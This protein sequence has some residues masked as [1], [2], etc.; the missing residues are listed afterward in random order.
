LHA[1]QLAIYPAQQSTNVPVACQS[2][3]S[4]KESPC[5]SIIVETKKREK[6]D[7]WEENKYTRTNE[8]GESFQW[9]ARALN[10]NIS[11]VQSS[12]L[13]KA[14]QQGKKVRGKTIGLSK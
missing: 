8:S 11:R 5:F 13:G 4:H 10:R 3:L 12:C 7:Q 1:Q 14:S 2:Q 6:N 9:A